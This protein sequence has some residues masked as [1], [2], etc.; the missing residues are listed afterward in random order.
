MFYWVESVQGVVVDVCN[1]LRMAQHSAVHTGNHP[2]FGQ[3]KCRVFT[4]GAKGNRI[5]F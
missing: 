4:F 5:Y 2:R 1:T 3:S